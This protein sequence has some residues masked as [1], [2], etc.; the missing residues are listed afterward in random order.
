MTDTQILEGDACY[1]ANRQRKTKDSSR[2][3]AWHLADLVSAPTL[4]L[5]FCVSFN[6]LLLG[7]TRGRLDT[8]I[9][10]DHMQVF[11]VEACSWVRCLL[12]C[13][14][15]NL[16]VICWPMK[17][18]QIETSKQNTQTYI[19]SHLSNTCQCLLALWSAQGQQDIYIINS[20][21][22]MCAFTRVHW[23]W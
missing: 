14:T 16:I 5:I 18:L 1:F 10:N 19:P 21:I 22:K 13:A 12:F 9:Y 4:L 3:W 17:P 23:F 15:A 11:Y 6:K 20:L 2:L 7:R 8:Q